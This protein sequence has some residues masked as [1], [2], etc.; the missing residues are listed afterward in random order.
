MNTLFRYAAALDE[1]DPAALAEVLTEDAT[2]TFKSGGETVA[3]PVVGRSAILDFVRAA[4]PGGQQRHH[5]TNVVVD[6]GTVRAYLLLTSTAGG[7]AAVV[8]TGRCTFG[9][10]AAG[11]EW[12]IAS[13]VVEFDGP[14]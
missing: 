4:K 12:R 13:L 6:G 2:W 9:L 10:R 1:R 8:N 3:G 14:M 11:D 7:R 5:L